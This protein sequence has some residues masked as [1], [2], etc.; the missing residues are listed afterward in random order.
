MIIKKKNIYLY[1]LECWDDESN[2][3]S[4]MNQAVAK[5]ESIMAKTNKMLENDHGK[6]FQNQ[7]FDL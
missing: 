7:N 5:L 2:N 6:L 3:R 4:D 1:F